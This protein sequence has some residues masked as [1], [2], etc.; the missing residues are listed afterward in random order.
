MG[1]TDTSY[2]RGD[3]DQDGDT[4]DDDLAAWN[5]LGDPLAR[6]AQITDPTER[7]NFV[8]DVL[9][10]WMGDSNLDG[11]FN[12]SDF[13]TVF[14]A[15]E[16]EDAIVGNSTWETGDWNGDGEFNS[17]DFVAAFSDGGYEQ[18]P[19]PVAAVPEPSVAVLLLTSIGL[20]AMRRR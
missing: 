13:V 12:S 16:Y 4:D 7:L 6:L 18:G 2:S 8:H 19:R 5:E 10:T 14:A 3:V 11:E 17:S 15:G 1:N 20:L 9:N